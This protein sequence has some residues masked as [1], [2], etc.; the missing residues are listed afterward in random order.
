LPGRP[1]GIVDNLLTGGSAFLIIY[2]NFQ[3][4]IMK[5]LKIFSLLAVLLAT[6]YASIA[7]STKTETIAVSGN[8]GMCKNT[9]EKAAKKAGATDAAWDMDTKTLT[10]TY[11]SPATNA[12]KIQQGIAAAGYDTR[13]F[14][15]TDAA[16]NKLHGCCKYERNADTKV[17]CCGDDKC[18]KDG[19]C[20]AEGK[21]K[22]KDGK[23]VAMAEAKE[24]SC[25]KNGACGKKS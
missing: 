22:M 19:S 6:S 9:I 24:M 12:A 15:A 21:C 10:V 4:T 8:C 5:T 20:C 17:S 14:K 11:N 25:C 16:Y 7:Q 23:C 13:D 1:A 3:I 18:A 2:F